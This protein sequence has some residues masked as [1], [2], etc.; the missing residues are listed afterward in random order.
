[1]PA[2]ASQDASK[3]GISLLAW[4]AGAGIGA[5]HTRPRG[6]GLK[7]DVTSKS[8]LEYVY[9]LK[10]ISVCAY[11]VLFIALGNLSGNAVTF[12][13]CLLRLVVL[14]FTPI[15]KWDTLIKSEAILGMTFV[16]LFQGISKGKS[17]SIIQFTTIVKV[18]MFVVDFA[19]GQQTIPLFQ[20]DTPVMYG[21]S[22]K[23]GYRSFPLR[24]TASPQTVIDL[25]ILTIYVVIEY[26]SS[27][28]VILR[29]R[30]NLNWQTLI[31]II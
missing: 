16:C 5:Y 11:G 13:S 29:F 6:G 31:C 30:Q 14:D 25:L 28:N 18:F 2:L 27:L 12:G 4:T 17:K 20:S 15:G 7:W 8:L 23:L 9:D 26:Q 22:S 21:D 3:I 19:P 24:R 10:W 1:M